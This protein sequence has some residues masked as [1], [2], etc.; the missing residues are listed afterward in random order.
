LIWKKDN[1][2]ARPL[3]KPMHLQ[4]VFSEAPYYGEK[5]AEDLFLGRSLSAIRFKLGKRRALQ[6]KKPF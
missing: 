5:T 6:D 3:W 1:I 2:E 4:P